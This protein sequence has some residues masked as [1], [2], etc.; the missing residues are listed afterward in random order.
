MTRVR[1]ALIISTLLPGT[2]APVARAQVPDFEPVTTEELL[3]PDDGDWINWRRTLNGQGYSPLDQID[4]DNVGSLQLVWSWAMQPGTDEVTPLVRDGV[5]YVP[6][7]S[8]VQALAAATGDLLWEHSRGA[9]GVTDESLPINRRPGMA[10]RNLAIYGDKLYAGTSRAEL[11]A[12]DARTGELVWQHRVADS[13]LG[14]RYTSG[15]IIVQGRVVAGM[16]GCERYKNDVCFISAHDPQTGAELWRTSTVARPGDPGGDTW[17]DLPLSWRAGAD[18]WIPGSYDPE[19]NLIYWSTA[20]AKPWASVQRGTEGAA[21]YTNS[22]LALDPETG[23]IAWYF[24]HIPAETH[25]LDEVFEIVI[26]DRGDGLSLFKMGKIG[27]LWELDPRTGAFRNAFDLGYQ[28]IVDI[29]P[30]RGQG[31]LRRERIPQV[32][33]PVDYC[34]GPGGVKNLWAMAYHPETQAFYVP[35]TPGCAHSVFGAMPEPE[36]GGGGVGPN[37]RRFTVHPDSPEQLGD[38]VA[39]DSRTGEVMWRRRSRWQYGTAALTTGGGLVFVGDIDRHMYA[40]DARDGTELWRTR[41][42]TATDGFPITYAVEGRQYIAV[43]SGPGWSISWRNARLVF[44][45]T[46]QRPP[47]SG[48][49]LQVFALPPDR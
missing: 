43:P 44:P 8:G 11:I 22:T 47:G 35:L 13:D 2:L 17:G 29:D 37:D 33:V 20:Q 23:E 45:E 34:P 28:N 49:V 31:I 16:T 26:V 14:Y 12:L 32:G 5:M 7:R 36:L 1:F 19:T 9:S 27:V 25:D 41:T 46:M 40:F 15:P 39:M 30:A 6:S 38:F 3:A 24:Q 48:S 21:L 4:R 42:P 18:G 10:R